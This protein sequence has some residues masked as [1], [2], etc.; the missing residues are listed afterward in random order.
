MDYSNPNYPQQVEVTRETLKELG[1]DNIPV[2]YAYN[3]TD[4]VKG[5]ILEIGKDCVFISAKTGAG[6]EKLVDAIRE[7]AF[8]EYVQCEMLIPYDKEIS[9][10]ISTIM[11]ILNQRYIKMRDIAVPGMQ[12]S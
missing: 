7:K 12:G 1:A 5:E 3:K 2:I 11:Q 8:K 10:P 6:M 4:L 9:S